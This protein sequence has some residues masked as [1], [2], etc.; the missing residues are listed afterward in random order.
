M[1]SPTRRSYSKFNGLLIQH[2]KVLSNYL[3]V[4]YSPAK[5]N[6]NNNLDMSLLSRKTGQEFFEI[7]E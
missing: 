6:H 4:C 2:R 7:V 1:A 5:E 3:L